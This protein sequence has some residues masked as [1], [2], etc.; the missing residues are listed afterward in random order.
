MTKEYNRNI[1]KRQFKK[2]H[3]VFADWKIDKE[4]EIESGFKKDISRWKVARFVKD[5][6]DFNNV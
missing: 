5:E 3:S 1:V 4:K 2:E 6:E